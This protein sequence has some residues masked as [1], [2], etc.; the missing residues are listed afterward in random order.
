M[1]KETQE[2]KT[3]EELKNALVKDVYGA[4]GLGPCSFVDEQLSERFKATLE[5]YGCVFEKTQAIPH[6][7]PVCGGSG[8]VPEGFYLQTSGYWSTTGTM[9]EQCRTCGGT[10]V[11]WG[12]G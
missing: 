7:C 1:K 10:G 2:Q 12:M 5:E 11:V 4:F 3:S 9:M 8:L 6:R